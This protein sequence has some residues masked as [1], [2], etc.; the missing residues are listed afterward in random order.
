MFH[1][2]LL[3]KEYFK[4]NYYPFDLLNKIMVLFNELDNLEMHVGYNDALLKTRSNDIYHWSPTKLKEIKLP[5]I[6]KMFNHC[7]SMYVIT[8]NNDLMLGVTMLT[9]NWD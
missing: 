8:R 4:D 9:V 6:K 3:L 1:A 5:S 7:G 2:Y